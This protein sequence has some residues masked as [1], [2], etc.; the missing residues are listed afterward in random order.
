MS[1]ADGRSEHRPAWAAG[2]PEPMHGETGRPVTSVIDVPVGAGGNT[3]S[4]LDGRRG[5]LITT[6]LGQRSG[7]PI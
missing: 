4:R 3:V 6:T 1:G 5:V 7:L 2:I